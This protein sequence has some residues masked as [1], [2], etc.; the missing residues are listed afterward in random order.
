MLSD[1]LEANGIATHSA[2]PD[3]IDGAIQSIIEDGDR[4]LT[5][6]Q[7]DLLYEAAAAM[8]RA[9]DEPSDGNTYTVELAVEPDSLLDW[10]KPLSSQGAKVDGLLESIRTDITELA[11]NFLAETRSREGYSGQALYQMLASKFTPS[12][13]SR[14]LSRHGIHGIRYL[15][16]GSRPHFTDTFNQEGAY[17]RALR[18]YNENNTPENKAALEAAD[19][20]WEEAKKPKPQTYNYVVFD[21]SNIRVVAKNGELL[22]GGALSLP[23]ES[24]YTEFDKLPRET[25]DDI[26][27][28]IATQVQLP[29]GE[30]P[31]YGGEW[32]EDDILANLRGLVDPP[33]LRVSEMRTSEIHGYSRKP[34]K[35]AVD[36]YVKMIRD[37]KRPPPILVDGNKF[38]DGGHR[39]AA[40][41]EADATI[42]VV[43]IGPLLRMD[44]AAWLKDETPKDAPVRS[45]LSR[46]SLPA[47]PQTDLPADKLPAFLKAAQSLIASGIEKPEA[48]AK[49][50]DAE[51][52]K[53][54]RKYS[55]ALWDAFG[56][57]KKSLRATHDWTA[58]YETVDITQG[59]AKREGNERPLGQLGG[60][61]EAGDTDEAG[62]PT[63]PAGVQPG[64]LVG[65]N[66]PGSVEGSG[67]EG[68]APRGS[69]ESGGPD[70][71]SGVQG[72]G[73]K[74]GESTANEPNGDIRTV[75]GAESDAGVG[76]DY[77]IEAG[78]LPQKFSATTRYNANIDAI[79]LL[80]KL[81]QENRQATTAEKKVL[82]KYVGWG[83]L[84]NAFTPPEKST[85]IPSSRHGS[86]STTR[87]RKC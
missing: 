13:A 86:L 62:N 76:E 15:D 36:N 77:R 54:Y 47:E 5:E 85:S 34:S 27:N 35:V 42:P 87:S 69:E 29:K 8:Q 80:K 7:R 52:D 79:R 9:A 25:Q 14:W 56:M 32:R 48:L 39:F 22:D 75:R 72:D 41:R 24:E 6:D 19:A 55:E 17:W 31:S 38:V 70:S 26:A 45:N 67:V 81:E 16:K 18:A 78:E 64:G 11:P 71:G 30:G 68:N 51:F 83:G 74:R 28:W 3:D 66:K 50:L 59:G 53:R 1:N 23:G 12:G 33:V 40:A 65:V 57:V 10:D 49:V 73:G 84:K 43:D 44:W 37:G 46:L 2:T 82:V 4:E 20:A 60:S 21:E 61:A 63:Q 58:I